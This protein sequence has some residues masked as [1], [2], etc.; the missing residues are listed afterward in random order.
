MRS[1]TVEMIPQT[2]YRKRC[3]LG[4]PLTDII[5]LH[6]VSENGMA[7]AREPAQ[8]ARKRKN[9][10]RSPSSSSSSSDSDLTEVA[11]TGQANT[12]RDTAGNLFDYT[13]GKLST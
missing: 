8:R 11:T 12:A 9:R 1:H 7:T 10:R 5:C 4:R 6:S 2:S 3:L 13:E